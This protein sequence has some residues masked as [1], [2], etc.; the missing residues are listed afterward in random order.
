MFKLSK[1]LTGGLA[2][3]VI[4]A[5]AG[6]ATVAQADTPAKTRSSC[7]F[8]SSWRGWSSPSPDVLLLR[9]NMR[10]VYRVQLVG[11]GS[12]SLNHAGYFLVNQVRGP[13]TI[14]SALDLDLAVA[15]HHGFYQPLI[16]RSLTKLTPAEVAAIP[17]KYRP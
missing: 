14:C 4:A 13:N 16:A 10:D 1:I 15:D 9:V 17:K 11:G 7:F 8:T 6:L 12:S 3:G 2:A 5:G